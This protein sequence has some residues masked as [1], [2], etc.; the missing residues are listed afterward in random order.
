[1][2]DIRLD[3]KIKS[4]KKDNLE[5][6][7]KKGEKIM[8]HIHD[9]MSELYD[10]KYDETYSIVVTMRKGNDMNSSVTKSFMW[11]WIYTANDTNLL[12]NQLHK[13]IKTIVDKSTI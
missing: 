2:E 7:T 1:M 4:I 5:Y 13:I 11:H 12:V 10:N 8:E 6:L 9:Y 3:N